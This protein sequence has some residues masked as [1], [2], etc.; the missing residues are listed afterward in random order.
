MLGKYNKVVDALSTRVNLLTTIL[1]GAMGLEI[2]N[3]LYV[4]DAN[5]GTQWRD[6]KEP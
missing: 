6:C 2:M 4:D 5:F 3:S 1:V